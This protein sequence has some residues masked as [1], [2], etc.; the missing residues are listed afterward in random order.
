VCVCAIHLHSRRI[1]IT[2][3]FIFSIIAMGNFL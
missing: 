2:Y 3:L 1:A